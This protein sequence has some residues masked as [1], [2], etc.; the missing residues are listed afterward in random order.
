MAYEDIDTTEIDG[1]SPLTELI[2][3][4]FKN[5]I[6]DHDHKDGG[7]QI[8]SANIPNDFVY[9]NHFSAGAVG[10]NELGSGIVDY[11]KVEREGVGSNALAVG[12]IKSEQLGSMYTSGSIYV[13]GYG[14][15]VVPQGILIIHSPDSSRNVEAFVNNTWVNFEY[16]A[17]VL[18]T[19]TLF[20]DG[21]NMRFRNAV[22]YSYTYRW[23]YMN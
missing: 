9:P 10:T 22:A 17:D 1:S 7:A 20:S 23:N 21:V 14:R 8:Q 12:C 16:D 19:V 2:I 3:R 13:G 18:E 11:T 4:K 15:E 6:E 5:N